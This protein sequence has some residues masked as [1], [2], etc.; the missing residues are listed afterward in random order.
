MSMINLYF[1]TI[2]GKRIFIT[3]PEDFEL[4]DM[5]HMIRNKMND[6]TVEN[7]IFFCK[8]RRLSMDDPMVFQ[9]QKRKLI[10]N[11]DVILV[12]KKML[13]NNINQ[14]TI[15]YNKVTYLQRYGFFSS[16]NNLIFFHLERIHD[17]NIFHHN[18]WKTNRITIENSF[19]KYFQQNSHF[20]CMGEEL[21]IHDQIIFERQKS[22]IRDRSVILHTVQNTKTIQQNEHNQL[23]FIERNIFQKFYIILTFLFFLIFYT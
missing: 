22:L 6:T 9:N 14:T 12:G 16:T 1:V 4:T 20:I 11:G 19:G 13:Y 10:N 18:E 3:L 17:D 23:L 5:L 15:N 2:P 8:G 21:N 7:C